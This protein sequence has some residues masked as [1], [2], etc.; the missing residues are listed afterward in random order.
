[1]TG[2]QMGHIS[3][4]KQAIGN[5]RAMQVARNGAAPV[6]PATVL[7]YGSDVKAL[8]HIEFVVQLEIFGSRAGTT[9]QRQ[10]VFTVVKEKAIPVYNIY[11]VRAG[12]KKIFIM[13]K[14]LTEDLPAP[15]GV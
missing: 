6:G 9:G 11:P 10:Q 7:V 3:A 8:Q 12:G 14:E 1:M 2:Q 5:W 15:V 13:I 4:G